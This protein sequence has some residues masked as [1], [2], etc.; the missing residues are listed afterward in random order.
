M[1]VECIRDQPERK[2]RGW[3]GGAR[4][5]FRLWFSVRAQTGKSGRASK[6]EQR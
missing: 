2:R 6:C 5:R 3:K 4:W 1:R